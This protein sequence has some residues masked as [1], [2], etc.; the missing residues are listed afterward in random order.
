MNVDEEQIKS[1]LGKIDSIDEYQKTND[2]PIKFSL[3][4]NSLLGRVNGY[5]PNI[6]V[7][8]MQ[9]FEPKIQ[10]P[11][12][13]AN[14]ILEQKTILLEIGLV[15]LMERYTVFGPFYQYPKTFYIGP[16]QFDKGVLKVNESD[17]NRPL[18]RDIDR[19]IWVKLS[20][21][22]SYV[23]YIDLFHDYYEIG[24]VKSEWLVY[25]PEEF[26]DEVNVKDVKND[27]QAIFDNLFFDGKAYEILQVK[28]DKKNQ[29]SSYDVLPKSTFLGAGGY[30]LDF[31]WIIEQL[32]RNRNTMNLKD[33]QLIPILEFPK[34]SGIIDFNRE[35]MLASTLIGHMGFVNPLNPEQ[36]LHP[37]PLGII[38][39]DKLN[40][41][42]LNI[43]LKKESISINE[44]HNL[45][46]NTY[47]ESESESESES[48]SK[49]NDDNDLLNF[50]IINNTGF[51]HNHDNN[52]DNSLSLSSSDEKEY[53]GLFSNGDT[54]ESSSDDNSQ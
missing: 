36:K 31:L 4:Y 30:H 38:N 20:S 35:Y 1:I 12:D 28:N 22:A 16:S 40:R 43:V 54:L 39:P 10:G 14:E 18:I 32:A 6:R 51:V 52:N 33:M 3:N 41:V 37:V 23:G 17:K 13:I 49:S 48:G 50:N 47:T 2:K 46:E 9:T 24:K 34:D 29:I 19:V 26:T 11:K 53:I 5:D 27:I 42:L 21:K 44:K 25:V 7:E 8:E 15:T 45:L